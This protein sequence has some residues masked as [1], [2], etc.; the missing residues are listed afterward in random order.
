MSLAQK[1][2]QIEALVASIRADLGI[3]KELRLSAPEYV[4]QDKPEYKKV[5]VIKKNAEIGRYT[6]DEFL[7]ALYE[8]STL[9]K[10]KDGSMKRV[11]TSLDRKL[12]PLTKEGEMYEK[13]QDLCA[14]FDL[15]V[16]R[17][18]P[19]KP[20]V[21]IIMKEEKKEGSAGESAAGGC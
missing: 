2:D 7:D 17:D 9:K 5:T 21:Y 4:K 8:S 11:V 14:D 16:V 15:E 12:W 19:S 1:L 18:D 20:N 13:L 10:F 3:K 6:E